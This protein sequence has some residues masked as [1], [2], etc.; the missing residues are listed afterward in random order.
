MSKSELRKSASWERARKSG[1]WSVGW[2]V[3][4]GLTCSRKV[5]SVSPRYVEMMAGGASMAP[6]RKSL[7]G[8]GEGEGEGWS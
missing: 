1:S 8:W 2:F 7:P 6:R 5:V 3:R 4:V